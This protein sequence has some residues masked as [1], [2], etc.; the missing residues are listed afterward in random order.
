M[1]SY[2]SLLT[3]LQKI[4]GLHPVDELHEKDA[5]SIYHTQI[6]HC[7]RY[8]QISRHC[9]VSRQRCIVIQ[10]I[11]K[12]HAVTNERFKRRKSL[13]LPRWHA[14]ECC[15]CALFVARERN[16]EKPRCIA[17]R[18]ICVCTLETSKRLLFLF[19][20][21]FCDSGPCNSSCRLL[22]TSYAQL[23]LPLLISTI[24]LSL[25]LIIFI[26]FSIDAEQRIFGE[27]FIVL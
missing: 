21:N 10:L 24:Y 19:K 1:D 12:L 20:T 26:G 6:L 5:K 23:F 4:K 27:Y 25:E 16:F 8:T 7:A 18:C 3:W 11:Y 15:D 17:H 9:F 13:F 2:L 22:N 14:L